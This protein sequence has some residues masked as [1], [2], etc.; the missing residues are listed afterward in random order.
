MAPVEHITPS[1]T[2]RMKDFQMIAGDIL[3]LI[4]RMS[5]SQYKEQVDAAGVIENFYDQ[6]FA[7]ISNQSLDLHAARL[8][9]ITE[10]VKCVGFQSEL[11][12]VYNDLYK[13][14]PN[15]ALEFISKSYIPTKKELEDAPEITPFKMPDT[16]VADLLG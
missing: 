13:K 9:A 14:D 5:K 11:K 7:L 8:Q 10:H 4:A 6:C 2:S 16:K 1:P 15:L 3:Q 12:G